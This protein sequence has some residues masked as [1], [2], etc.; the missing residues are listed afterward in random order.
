[1]LKYP[2]VFL[3]TVVTAMET[4]IV[5]L[6]YVILHI[7]TLVISMIAVPVAGGILLVSTNDN[8]SVLKREW[9]AITSMLIFF[10][11]TEFAW[12]NAIGYLGAGKT[13]LINVPLETISVVVLAWIFLH[14]KLDRFKI[15]GAVL[16]MIGVILSFNIRT[17]TAGGSGIGE[18]LIVIASLSGAITVIIVT[19]LLEKY[20][21]RQITGFSLLFAGLILQ[22][23]WFF[24]RLDF[25]WS[26]YLTLTPIVPLAVFFLQNLSYK[27]V[28]ASLT[29]I[30]VS[31]SIILVVVLQIILYHIGLPVLLPENLILAF[32]GGLISIVGIVIITCS[33]RLVK[34]ESSV[35]Q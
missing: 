14:E 16:I 18:L 8:I 13:Q 29:S 11:I 17:M 22:F 25:Q 30:I 12:Y 19:K 27:R 6:F 31:T 34:R 1:M 21:T 33:E 26:W 3:A 28:G 15:L 9:K 10:T 32:V 23:Q 24:V 7:P 2:V 4:I 5:E 35:K 20:E